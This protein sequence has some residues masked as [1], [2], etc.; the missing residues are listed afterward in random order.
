MSDR[1][2]HTDRRGSAGLSPRAR[3]IL[4]GVFSFAAVGSLLLVAVDLAVGRAAAGDVFI[5]LLNTLAAVVFWR[6]S[7]QSRRT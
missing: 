6:W 1:A 7:A 2:P 3:R 5:V 4:A